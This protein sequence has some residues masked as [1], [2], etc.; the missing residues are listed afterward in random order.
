[1]DAVVV[2]IGSV[3]NSSIPTTLYVKEMG[4]KQV[5]AKSVS[6]AHGSILRKIGADE[7]Y[8]SKNI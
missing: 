8:F 1:M 7:I 2:G 4:V 3:L 5:A 6:E